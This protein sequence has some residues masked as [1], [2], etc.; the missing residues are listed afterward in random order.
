[1][2]TMPPSLI[3]TPAMTSF[4]IMMEVKIRCLL[5]KTDHHQEAPEVGVVP[6]ERRLE[7][8]DK[9]FSTKVNITVSISL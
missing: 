7:V 9:K 4:M 6:E 5:K 2:A 3:I 1:M 8:A